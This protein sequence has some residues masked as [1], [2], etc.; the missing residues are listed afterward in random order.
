MATPK[1]AVFEETHWEQTGGDRQ[2][3]NELEIHNT[4]WRE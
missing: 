2:R 3:G 4:D 1:Q